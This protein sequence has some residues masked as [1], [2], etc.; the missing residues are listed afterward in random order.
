MS[1]PKYWLKCTRCGCDTE[2]SPDI[3]GCYECCNLVDD[4]MCGM[5]NAE[6]IERAKKRRRL[7]DDEGQL[8]TMVWNSLPYRTRV[9]EEKTRRCM[10]QLARHYLMLDA[11]EKSTGDRVRYPLSLVSL[12]TDCASLVRCEYDELCSRASKPTDQQPEETNC[13][14]FALVNPTE[15]V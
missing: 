1:T 12:A 6:T 4:N 10:K 14:S 8:E 2:K 3:E 15:N 11:L 7:E 9:I 13:P 5:W